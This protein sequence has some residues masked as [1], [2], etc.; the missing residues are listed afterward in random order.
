MA[1][2]RRYSRKRSQR[3]NR[4]ASRKMRGGEIL[5]EQE[6]YT[7]IHEFLQEKG[8]DTDD[9]A[10][11]NRLFNYYN[12]NHNI[13][14]LLG[15]LTIT[16]NLV[17]QDTLNNILDEWDNID[18]T[19]F[20]SEDN[21]LSNDEEILNNSFSVSEGSINTTNTSLFDDISVIDHVDDN[22]QSFDSVGTFTLDDTPLT[23]DELNGGKRRTLAKKNKRK[24]N[25]RKTKKSKKTRKNRKR[26]Q[27]G[28]NMTVTEDLDLQNYKDDEYN[29]MKNLG[30][31]PKQ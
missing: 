12:R 19:T 30:L 5:D 15:A 18:D 2:H 10:V 20:L 13:D 9:M 28:G 27:Y 8:K 24:T 7:K 25:K 16:F 21:D 31:Y 6:F 29:Q 22:N 23:L 17:P 3:R 1:K 11:L 4:R 26:R 14:R